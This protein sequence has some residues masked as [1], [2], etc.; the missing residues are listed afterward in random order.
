MQYDHSRVL[1]YLSHD[2]ALNYDRIRHIIIIIIIIIKDICRV[3]H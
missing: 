3:Q 1:I 2:R